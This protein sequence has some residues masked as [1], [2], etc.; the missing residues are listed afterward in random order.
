MKRKKTRAVVVFGRVWAGPNGCE[1]T[2]S[3]YVNGE[4]VATLEPARGSEDYARQRAHEWLY[5]H[6]Y[7]PGMKKNK[8]GGLEPMW[9]W[10]ARNPGTTA[11]F[12]SAQVERMKYL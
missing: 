7:L 4:Q 6:G 11:I 1:C 8:W 5:E 3:V 2:S 12:E 10:L 9:Q